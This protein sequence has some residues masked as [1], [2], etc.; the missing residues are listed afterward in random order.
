MTSSDKQHHYQSMGKQVIES[1]LHESLIEHL[2]AE[3]ALKSIKTKQRALEWLKS[4]FLYGSLINFEF[5]IYSPHQKE[6]ILLSIEK[7]L[8]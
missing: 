5:I 6:S 4:T 8:C 7:L 1:S 2:N 3:I